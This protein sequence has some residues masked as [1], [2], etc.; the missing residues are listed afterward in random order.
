VEGTIAAGQEV[1]VAF[2]TGEGGIVNIVLESDAGA[3][4][5]ILGPDGNLLADGT[6]PTDPSW[7]GLELPPNFDLLLQIVTEENAGEGS[8]TLTIEAAAPA[9]E[10]TAE[11]T[12][13]P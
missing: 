10:A 9:A 4:V 2:N 3:Y 1:R 13:A 5:N 8:Y 7:E 11:A 12:A 6:T